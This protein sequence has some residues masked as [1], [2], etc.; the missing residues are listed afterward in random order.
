MEVESTAQA[1]EALHAEVEWI[2]LDKAF[3]LSRLLTPTTLAG[4]SPRASA[5]GRPAQRF[6]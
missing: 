6:G 5:D 1:I 4:E 3:E 2:T